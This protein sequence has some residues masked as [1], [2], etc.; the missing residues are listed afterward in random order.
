[1]PSKNPKRGTPQQDPDLFLAESLAEFKRLNREELRALMEQIRGDY[2]AQ[3]TDLRA[4]RAGL[5]EAT[6]TQMTALG[7]Q[8]D[9]ALEAT[10]NSALERGMLQSGVYAK[11][12]GNVLEQAGAAE[13][14]IRSNEQNQREQI[15]TALH[16]L[17][18][19]MSAEIAAARGDSDM[20]MLQFLQQQ[21]WAN[22]LAQQP[23]APVPPPAPV[24]PPVVVPPAQPMPPQPAPW[25]LY[26]QPGG[27]QGITPPQPAYTGGGG[28]TGAGTGTMT[29]AQ[30]AAYQAWYRQQQ[31]QPAVRPPAQPVR[32]G[33]SPKAI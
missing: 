13:M 9:D 30:L 33:P 2:R 23:V 20:A 12:V 4:Q 29:P 17:R 31:T 32:P 1:M 8:K 26:G 6:N 27:Y 16:R 5:D 25:D 3:R 15:N 10:Q 7:Q 21:Q 19:D 11:G 22:L 28:F 18:G 24:I 14:Q